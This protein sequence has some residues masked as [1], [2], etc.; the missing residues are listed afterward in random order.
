LEQR[1]DLDLFPDTRDIDDHIRMIGIVFSDGSIM[2]RGGK[3]TFSAPDHFPSME[4]FGVLR[5]FVS[6]IGAEIALPALGTIFA[7]TLG[8]Y[9]VERVRNR[10]IEE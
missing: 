4:Q 1:H 5:E 10:K 2:R 7:L 8:S 3:G 9:G 6:A